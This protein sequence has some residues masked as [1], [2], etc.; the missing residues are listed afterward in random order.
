MKLLFSKGLLRLGKVVEGNAYT[1]A[2]HFRIV[3]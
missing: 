3:K 1:V 2:D